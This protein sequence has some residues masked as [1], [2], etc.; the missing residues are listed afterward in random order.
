[1]LGLSDVADTI[2]PGL[3]ADDSNDVSKRDGKDSTDSIY[4]P[5]VRLSYTP[6]IPLPAPFPKTLHVEG[7]HLYI[8]SS[9]FLRHTLN[10]IYTDLHV[11][12]RQA[13][14]QSMPSSPSSGT[15]A[16][17]SICYL[18]LRA[19]HS[20]QSSPRRAFREKAFVLGLTIRGVSRVGKAPAQWDVY[21]FSRRDLE[22]TCAHVPVY[23]N[24]TYTFSPASGL[25]LLHS[26]DS[27]EPAPT[28]ALFEA[29]GKFGLLG[30][31]GG[32]G[33]AGVGS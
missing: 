12:L 7:L 32:R 9:V 8:A 14:V 3:S 16:F 29:L 6:P 18:P 27:I 25:V 4:S 15:C 1:M 30:G 28:Q 13:R 22:A 20:D 33:G 21:V 23:S 10:A 19:D 5:R 17:M 2:D 24:C 11:D 26:I 31:G